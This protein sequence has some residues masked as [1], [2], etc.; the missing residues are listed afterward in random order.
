MVFGVLAASGPMCALGQ[1]SVPASTPA[2]NPGRLPITTSSPEAAKLFEEG[3][4]LSYN[5]HTEQALAK[6]REATRKDPNFTQAWVYILWTTSDPV[7]EKAAVEKAL[8]TSQNAT[9]G[10]KLLVKWLTSVEGGHFVDAITAMNDLLAMYP[11]DTELNFEAEIWLDGQREYEAAAKFGKR[12]LEVD[13]NFVAA[14]NNLA[15]DLAGMHQYDQ[16]IPYLKRYVELEPGEPNPR[17]SLAEILQKAGRLE[18]SLAEYREAL[19]LDPKYYTSQMGLGN[20]YALQGK[21]D[22]AREE[23]A[24]AVP[25]ASI[26]QDKLEAEIQSAVT[27]AREGNSKQARLELSAVLDEATKL[28]L[29]DYRNY[30][31]QEL[32]LLTDSPAAALREIDEAEAVLRGPGPLS[33]ATRDAALGRILRMRARIAAEAGNLEIARTAVARLQEMLQ[34]NHGYGTE[35]SYHAANGALLAAEKKTAA[36][37]EELQQIPDE[38]FSM[39]KLAELQAAAGNT[40]DAAE[41]RARLQADYRPYIED[42]LVVRKF[43]P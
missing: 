37:I 17:D 12:A 40:R 7:E 32:A 4:R 5:L 31:H 19:K 41:T 39:A 10:E 22:R 25:M 1:T 36:A 18:E 43:R 16:A 8:L 42:W 23:Y 29:T 2:G 24:K 11:R 3:L 13:P 9:P 14:L 38:P 26:P 21:Q 30:I 20:D 28:Q 15:Y 33:P 35:R 34:E 6:L 27:Y